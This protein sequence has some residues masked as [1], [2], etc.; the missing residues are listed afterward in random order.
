MFQWTHQK[1]TSSKYVNFENVQD[2]V[3]S[4]QVIILV[5]TMPINEQSCLIKNTVHAN[6]EEQI[7][8]DMLFKLT[9]PDRPVF[10]YGKNDSD[11]R[12]DEKY[13]NLKKIGVE[14]VYI[15]KGGMF[16]WMLLQDIYG[17]EEFPTTSKLIDILSF[18]PAKI[19]IVK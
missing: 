18:R 2:A 6:D 15:Y 3:H 10:I 16:E 7:I 1:L 17:K 13:N 5:N 11:P 14:S 12:V 19:R 8:N 9:V 4:N